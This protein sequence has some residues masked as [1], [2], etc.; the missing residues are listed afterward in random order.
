[1]HQ[2][3]KRGLLV[4]IALLLAAVLLPTAD[5]AAARRAASG[6]AIGYVA[7]GLLAQ[8]LFRETSA[9]RSER[10]FSARKLLL[11]LG[12]IGAPLTLALALASW[13]SA[14]A[15]ALIGQ[16]YLAIV[17]GILI[18]ITPVLMVLFGILEALVRLLRGAGGG[19][20]VTLLPTAGPTPALPNQTPAVPLFLP[21]WLTTFIGLLRYLV[22]LLLLVLLLLLRSRRT[23]PEVG[24]AEERESVWSWRTAGHDLRAWWDQLQRRLARPERDVLAARLRGDDPVTVIRR[25]Y[26]RLLMRGVQ[27]GRARAPEQTPAEYEREV[28]RL[29]PAQADAVETLTRSYERARYH[30]AAVTSAQAADAQTAWERLANAP[31]RGPDDES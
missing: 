16:V 7:A 2:R 30:P 12:A 18:I 23:A 29:F 25:V 13:V 5:P 28:L 17:Q 15:A 21:V 6:A 10:R 31:P 11:L 24:A 1:V 19:T 22:P 8:A 9:E 26:V 27:A 4:L 20:P 14:D 3:F